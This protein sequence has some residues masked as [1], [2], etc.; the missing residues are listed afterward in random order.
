MNLCFMLLN[1]IFSSLK[2]ISVIFVHQLNISMNTNTSALDDFSQQF[3][4]ILQEPMVL[5]L[6]SA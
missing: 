2:L 4:L 5:A 3:L 6:K 1:I